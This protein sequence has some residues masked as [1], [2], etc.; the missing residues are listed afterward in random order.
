M[1]DT[2]KAAFPC[3]CDTVGWLSHIQE[4][5]S[6]REYYAGQALAGM[7]RS[8]AENSTQYPDKIEKIV[9]LQSKLAVLSADALIAELEGGE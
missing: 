7:T 5:I 3:V 6:L 1:K 9:K 2:S 4:G 8:L